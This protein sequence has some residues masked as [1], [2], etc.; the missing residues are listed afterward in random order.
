MEDAIVWELIALSAAKP[1]KVFHPQSL[2]NLQ[3]CKVVVSRNVRS[4]KM[5]DTWQGTQARFLSLYFHQGIFS[6]PL[7]RYEERFFISS[8]RV[9]LRVATRNEEM[10]NP[11]DVKSNKGNKGRGILR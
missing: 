6:Q 1:P 3:R 2:I 5:D 7:L 4:F 10:P 11:C 9:W 8:I